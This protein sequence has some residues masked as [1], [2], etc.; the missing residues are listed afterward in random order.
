MAVLELM[1]KYQSMASFAVTKTDFSLRSL[2]DFVEEK[3]PSTWSLDKVIAVTEFYEAHIQDFG[4]KKDFHVASELLKILC[5]SPEPPT[6]LICGVNEGQ[7]TS[8]LVESCPSGLVHGF[9][10]QKR[11][12]DIAAAK[13]APNKNVVIHHQ[14]L[15]ETDGVLP[16]AGD[17]EIAGLYA[18]IGRWEGSAQHRAV[19]VVS[20][21]HVLNRYKIPR[22]GYCV[23]DV[24]GHEQKVI[25]GMELETNSARFPLFQYELGGTWADSRRAG[26][27]TQFSTSFYLEALGY[28]IYLMGA[29]GETG[30][31]LRTPPEFYRLSKVNHE[32]F[33]NGGQKYFV[34][35]NALAV[36][37]Q[38]V[39]VAVKELIDRLTVQ[40][41]TVL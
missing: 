29:T 14:G 22:V 20:P 4:N 28:D 33:T 35:G 18:P 39:S 2:V 32:G 17:G 40:I 34:Q 7:G 1:L 5:D 41:D 37:F 9:E 30:M 24:E 19:E 13:F 26:S 25:K 36:N 12:F 11:E 38:H 8:V 27:W 6:V 23:I 3:L 31:L 16:I 10:I 15:S 21:S